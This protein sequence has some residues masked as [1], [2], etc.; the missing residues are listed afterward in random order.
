MEHLTIQPLQDLSFEE[1]MG[2]VLDLRGDNAATA[3]SSI[4][5]F[6]EIG[7]V[8]LFQACSTFDF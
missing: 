4:D 3:D 5:F 8:T 7:G 2:I 6:Q 1:F